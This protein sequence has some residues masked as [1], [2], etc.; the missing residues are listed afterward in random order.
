LADTRTHRYVP[1]LPGNPLILA[2]A[3]EKRYING[4]S[5]VVM[6]VMVVAAVVVVA[7]AAVAVVVQEGPDW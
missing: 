2:L 3:T 1:S 7:S 5:V 4:A 6:V